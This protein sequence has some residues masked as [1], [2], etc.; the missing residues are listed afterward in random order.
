MTEPDHELTGALHRLREQVRDRVAAPPAAGLRTR[1]SHRLRVRRLTTA[2]LAATAV[3][4]VALGGNALL[5]PTAV[6]PPLPPV[7][8]PSP[9][10]TPTPAGPAVTPSPRPEPRPVVPVDDPIAEV[11]WRSATIMF[12]PED[13]CPD[14]PIDFVAV[15]DIFPTALGPPD[16][17]PAIALDATRAAYGD[18]TGDGRLEAVLEARCL[19]S[20]EDLA[21][22][23][24][25]R[26]L[27]VTRQD[28]GALTAL[29]RVGPPGATFLSWWVDRGRLLINADPATAGAEHHFVPVPGLA[30]SY[31]WDGTGFGDWEPAPEYPP[32]VPLDPEGTGAPVQPRAAVAAGLGCPD[33]ELRFVPFGDGRSGDSLDPSGYLVPGGYGQQYLFDLDRTGARLLVVPLDCN[34]PDGTHLTGLAVFERAGDGWQGISVLLPPEGYGPAAWFEEEGGLLRVDWGAGDAEAPEIPS[35][36][37]R[38]T[39][40]V[41]ERVNG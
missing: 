40:T 7:E 41:L 35:T 36:M 13:G 5:Q 16:R 34:R 10:V 19:S 17:Y 15:S 31:R 4:A 37:H 33:T 20:G 3:I 21:S 22:G 26:L 28:D 18:L 8:P 29:G 27:V 24:G 25:A 9:P 30:L 23:H 6:P 12:P 11:A 1:A 39:G 32:V 38:W 14:G 2:G